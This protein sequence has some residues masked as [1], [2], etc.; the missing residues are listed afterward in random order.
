MRYSK[1]MDPIIPIDVELHS[2]ML[3]IVCPGGTSGAE[4]TPISCTRKANRYQLALK[5]S[6]KPPTIIDK[7]SSVYLWLTDFFRPKIVLV[8]DLSLGFFSGV[9]CLAAPRPFR[10]HPSSA[11]L[12]L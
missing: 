11:Y 12:G 10:S 3:K 7:S 5:P 9:V 6:P 8:R 2:S 4:Y 1:G